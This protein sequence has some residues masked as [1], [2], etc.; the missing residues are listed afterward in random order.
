M[1]V[2]R[3]RPRH[4]GRNHGGV[5]Q[6]IARK[7]ARRSLDRAGGATPP[8]VG[9]ASRRLCRLTDLCKAGSNRPRWTLV[10]GPAL[11]VAP[12]LAGSNRPHAEDRPVRPAKLRTDSSVGQGTTKAARPPEDQVKRKPSH[13]ATSTQN[14]PRCNIRQGT[15]AE[16]T[17][18]DNQPRIKATKYSTDPTS[19][20]ALGYPPVS[21]QA[22]PRTYVST[23][24]GHQFPRITRLPTSPHHQPPHPDSRPAHP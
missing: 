7:L 16:R 20:R 9:P 21:R 22:S 4:R 18:G 1:E 17:Q 8:P 23:P 24:Q 12:S 5:S 13:Q 19:Q 11:F 14:P 2:A 6:A 10:T 15:K 3:P